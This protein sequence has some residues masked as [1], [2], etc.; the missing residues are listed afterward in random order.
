MLACGLKQSR[1]L[2]REPSCM[3]LTYCS[4][5]AETKLAGRS[6]TPDAP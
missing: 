2:A 6:G 4:A 1:E 5:L 3:V